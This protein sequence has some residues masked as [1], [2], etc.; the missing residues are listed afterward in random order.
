MSRAPAAA[1]AALAALALTACSG[2]P[3]RIDT[4]KIE[5]GIED[6]VERKRP[7]DDVE[8]VSCPSNVKLEK[9][10]VFKCLVRSTKGEEVEATVVQ[11]DDQGL[12]RYVV[13]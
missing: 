9:G 12:V 3:E 2:D 6:E 10:H 4:A 13:P 1:L 5:R 11:V 8:S 7:T